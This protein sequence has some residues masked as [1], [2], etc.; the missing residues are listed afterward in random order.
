MSDPSGERGQRKAKAD[1]SLPFPQE[2]RDRIPFVPQGR[3]DDS[4]L[5]YKAA[6]ATI[7]MSEPDER[8]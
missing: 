3:R 5:F 4:V 7:E 6:A 8:N 2:R 1:P